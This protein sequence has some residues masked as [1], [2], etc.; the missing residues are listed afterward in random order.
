MVDAKDFLLE[1]YDI[2]QI[3]FNLIVWLTTTFT[4]KAKFIINLKAANPPKLH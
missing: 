3:Y 2:A 1:S 4:D